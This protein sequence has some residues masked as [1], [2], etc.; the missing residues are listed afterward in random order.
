MLTCLLF[1]LLPGDRHNLENATP[2]ECL[3]V[4]V[5]KILDAASDSLAILRNLSPED[6]VPSSVGLILELLHKVPEVVDWAKRSAC[7]R[8]ATAALSLLTS[9]YGDQ[10]ELPTITGGYA[11]SATGEPASSEHIQAELTRCAP[12]ADRVLGMVLLDKHQASQVAPEDKGK[13]SAAPVDYPKTK[14]F[15]AAQ[16]DA[17]SS[18][19]RQA[20]ATRQEFLAHVRIPDDILGA[21]ASPSS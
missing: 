3:G 21:F 17:L 11:P 6:Q 5:T 16:E 7:R 15:A 8:G 13:D 2:D 20:P 19:A 14:L 1:S 10:V 12:Y 4:L 9:H 18:F